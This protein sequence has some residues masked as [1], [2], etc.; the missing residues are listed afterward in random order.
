MAYQAGQE[1][2][3]VTG[4]T[5]RLTGETDGNYNPVVDFGS[6]VPYPIL[7]SAITG[8]LIH[9]FG[10]AREAYDQS[11][12]RGAICDG[13]V[14][15][16]PSEGVAAVRYHEWVVAVEDQGQFHAFAGGAAE[17]AATD[18]GRYAD[19]VRLAERAL[20]DARASTVR[21]ETAGPAAPA[22]RRP[23]DGGPS[24][25]KPSSAVAPEGDFPAANPLSGP[26]PGVDRSRLP[27]RGPAARARPASRPHSPGQSV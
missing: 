22:R 21:V 1:V 11:R 8:P 24:P 12:I 10:S 17:L 20:E 19:S 14:L 23:A 27:S 3:T 5:G 9:V 16:V 15:L 13:D 18:G 6:G 7:R 26:A 2:A 4:R 25:G